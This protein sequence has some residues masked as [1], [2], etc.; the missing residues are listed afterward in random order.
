MYIYILDVGFSLEI[1][2]KFAGKCNIGTWETF[3]I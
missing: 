2:L 1:C 3:L